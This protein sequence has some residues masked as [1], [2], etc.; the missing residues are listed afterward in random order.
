MRR[1]NFVNEINMNGSLHLTNLRK[2]NPSQGIQIMANSVIIVV[3]SPV[4]T[5]PLRHRNK[6]M[7]TDLSN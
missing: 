3:S 6:C 2:G 4:S 7:A 5:K 1:M